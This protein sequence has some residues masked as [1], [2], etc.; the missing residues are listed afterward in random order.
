MNIEETESEYVVTSENHPGVEVRVE[1][2]L[3]DLAPDRDLFLRNQFKQLA[4]GLED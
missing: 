2:Q 4:H 3:A 1:K